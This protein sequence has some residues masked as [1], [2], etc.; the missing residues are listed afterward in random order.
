MA[1]RPARGHRLAVGQHWGTIRGTADVLPAV[2][3]VDI[4]RRWEPLYLTLCLI[5]SVRGIWSAQSNTLLLALLLLATVAAAR[6][7]VVG[8]ALSGS[9]GTHQALAGRLRRVAVRTMAAQLVLRVA[10]VVFA[11]ALIPFVTATPEHAASCYSDW[12]EALA[13]RHSTGVRFPGYRDAWTIAELR[14]ASLCRS[15]RSCGCKWP[16]A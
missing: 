6:P 14:W 3:C 11:L 7:V 4:R 16:A 10:V 15:R 13:A 8:G 5:A 2:R 12:Y 1:A 9:A